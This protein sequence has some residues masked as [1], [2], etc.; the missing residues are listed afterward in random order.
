MEVLLWKKDDW[1]TDFKFMYISYN[2]CIS[3]T[4]F[5]HLSVGTCWGSRSCTSI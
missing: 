4:L 1:T 5:K 2:C 3:P